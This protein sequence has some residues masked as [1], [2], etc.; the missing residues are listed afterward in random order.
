MFTF[1][2]QYIFVNMDPYEIV[3]KALENLDK[4]VITGV[5]KKT[6]PKD[7]DG[8]IDLLIDNQH[9]RLFIEIK[10]ELRNHQLPKIQELAEKHKNNFLVVAERIFP[11][12]K[13]E[14]RYNKIPYLEGNG[15]IWLK[16]GKIFLWIDTNKE[17]KTKKE[18]TN[19]AF[20]KT[21]LKV[22]FH[23]L[24]NEDTVN[25]TYRELA[26]VT[27]VGL[28]NINYVING[29]KENN[30]LVKLD[31]TRY[32]LVNKKELLEK[33]M[34]AY[35]ERLKPELFIGAFRLVKSEDF[36]KW[37]QIQFKNK[38]TVWGGEPAGDILTN[39]L[40]PAELT[41]YTKETKAELIKNYRLIPDPNGNIKVY[42]KF[43]DK[44][45]NGNSV[46]PILAYVDLMN[47]GDQRNI[48][49][50]LKINTNA[51]QNKL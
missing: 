42:K 34:I 20:T 23:F 51:L 29:L 6:A 50:A 14:L 33:W 25:Q 2:E 30:Y 10:K 18:K 40:K 36:I 44:G 27:G 12:I 11:K 31:K 35:Q 5:L 49:T 38:D 7:L 3:H 1:R 16:K 39:Y 37:K 19:R 9:Y 4:T 15:N 21:G 22:L 46:P 13:E 26:H 45:D 47:T 8:E 17:L 43:W 41:I 28:G 32:K 48:E 24:L